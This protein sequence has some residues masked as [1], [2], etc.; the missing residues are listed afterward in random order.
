M[1]YKKRNTKINL[2]KSVNSRVPDTVHS[3]VQKIKINM[4]PIILLSLPTHLSVGTGLFYWYCVCRR[5]K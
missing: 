2:T 3:T 5:Y 1:V 4:N